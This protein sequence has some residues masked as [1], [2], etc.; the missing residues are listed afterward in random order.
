MAEAVKEITIVFKKDKLDDGVQ[1]EIEKIKVKLKGGGNEDTIMELDNTDE[2]GVKNFES[3]NG[4]E[5][6]L[7]SG[8]IKIGGVRWCW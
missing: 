2:S 5:I 4:F 1:E 3:N 7:G 6:W 8:C